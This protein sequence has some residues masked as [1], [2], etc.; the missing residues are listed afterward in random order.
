M[1]LLQEKN[2][3]LFGIN[4]PYNKSIKAHSDGD[5]G[6]HALID[7]ILGT[8]S[9]GDIGTHFPNNDKKYKNINSLSLL[10]KTKKFFK[11]IKEKLFILIIL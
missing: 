3:K 8:L 9:V 7:A 11:K 4:I 10:K 2:F 5:V 6:V 1:P